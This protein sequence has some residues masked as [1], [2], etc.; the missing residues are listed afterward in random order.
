M[1]PFAYQP[2]RPVPWKGIDVALLFGLLFLPILP[3]IIATKPATDKEQKTVEQIEAP[4]DHAHP[5]GRLL[6][7]SQSVWPLLLGVALA[8]V[9]A[10]LMEELY[11]RLL[12][13][14]WLESLEIRF[15]RPLRIPCR[16]LGV[17][18]ITMV[19]LL[20]ASIHY[21]EARPQFDLKTILE[22]LGNMA[23]WSLLNIFVLL[24]WLKFGVKAT[25]SDLGFDIQKLG[26]DIAVGL[27]V[28]F[29]VIIA[30]A[31]IKLSVFVFAPES[32][33]APWIDPVC[34]VPLASA[35]GFLYYRTHRIV[36]SIVVHATFNL[37]FGVLMAF[38]FSR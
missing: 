10:P 26:I 31:A 8:V 23:A 34:L 37:I 22:L 2:R 12:L 19:V 30:T 25:A 11:F 35:L 17:V 29:V 3:S 6:A 20:F 36:P 5:L 15:R 33:L 24:L 13:Q 14:G 18:P 27:A 4:K 38:L 32:L 7:E 9:I 28:T 21:R 16:W 1:N